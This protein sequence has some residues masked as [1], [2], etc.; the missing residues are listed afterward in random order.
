MKGLDAC[1]ASFLGPHQ[2]HELF[3]DATKPVPNDAGIELL[4]LNLPTTTGA[5]S[6]YQSVLNEDRITAEAS[7]AQFESPQALAFV[8]AVFRR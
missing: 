6:D 7:S 2:V 8:A 3:R 4:P 5:S 1:F